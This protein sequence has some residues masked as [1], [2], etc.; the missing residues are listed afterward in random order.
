M[1]IKKILVTLFFLMMSQ[2]VFAVQCAYFSGPKVISY[3][4]TSNLN[5][6]QNTAGESFEVIG[7]P[8]QQIR[9]KCPEEPGDDSTFRSYRTDLP[10][11]ES[12]GKYQ[13]Y[14]LNEYLS[15]AMKI[16]DS[17]AGDFYPPVDYVQMGT[18]KCVSRGC[19]FP[20]NDSNLTFKVKVLTP[21]VGSV[22]IPPK[23]MFN[24]YVS[25]TDT[26]SFD[27]ILYQINYSGSITVPQ[28]C[29]I[30]AGTVVTIDFGDIGA[31]LFSNAGAGN[32]PTGVNAQSRTFGI[33]C[34]NI[35]A[36]ATLSMRLES[37]Q[38]SG[39]AMVSDNPDLGFVVADSKNNPLVPNDINSHFKFKLDEN[40]ESSVGITA[41]PVSITGKK[42]KEG[43]FTSEGYLRVDFD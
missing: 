35:D 17:W 19:D 43:T 10:I 2:H 42:P 3:D 21:F 31:S 8:G 36:E 12:D 6:I 38:S 9:A 14:K 5:S 32:K 26:D 28:S 25:T 18:D 7:N 24:V 13:F 37:E 1:N 34:K 30:N 11:L 41:W 20:I 39:N 27:S 22:V 15:A 29:E 4:I 33:K 40:A 23:V 16:S